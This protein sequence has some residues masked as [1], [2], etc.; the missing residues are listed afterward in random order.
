[1]CCKRKKGG[2]F[3]GVTMVHI[4]GKSISRCVLLFYEAPSWKHCMGTCYI[5]KHA[6]VELEITVGHQTLL[7]VFVKSS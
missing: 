1:M 3:E 5:H 6:I 4:G 7:M 2:E